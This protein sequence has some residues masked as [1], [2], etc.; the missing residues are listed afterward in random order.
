MKKETYYIIGSSDFEGS[1]QGTWSELWDDTE[2][3]DIDE[4]ER[5]FNRAKL[6]IIEE[7]ILT[8]T[9]CAVLLDEDG[10]YLMQEIDSEVIKEF[11]L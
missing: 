6:S 11:S 4:A 1:Y 3:I 2:L 10:D 7:E 8:I 9:K 5:L